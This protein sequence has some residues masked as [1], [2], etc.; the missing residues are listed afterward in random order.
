MGLG[1]IRSLHIFELRKGK[2]FFLG[3]GGRSGLGSK[4][5][6]ALLFGL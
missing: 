3:S 2:F 5:I 4:C 6:V 1:K